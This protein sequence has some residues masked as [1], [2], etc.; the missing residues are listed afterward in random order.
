VVGMLDTI[1]R[2]RRI[3]PILE[4]EPEDDVAK[5][6]PGRL[7]GR[8]DVDRA[9]FRYHDD[10]PKVLDGVSLHAEPGEFVAIVGP[11]GSGK[12]TILRL[13]LGYETPVT[14]SVLYDG[15]NLTGLDITAVRRQLG[16]VLQAGRLN[17]GSIFDNIACGSVISI[18]EAWEA[19]HHAG[20]AE[21]RQNA[22]DVAQE[23]V[24]G[25]NDEHTGLAEVGPLVVQEVG[26]PVQRDDRLAGSRASLDHQRLVAGGP[27]DRIL[28][29]L[30]RRHHRQHL[31]LGRGGDRCEGALRAATRRGGP[32]ECGDQLRP[33]G[34]SARCTGHH[35]RRR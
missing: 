6:D 18:D 23:L 31:R 13:L 29:G 28:L 15:Q 27:D 17:T 33:T 20:L 2:G 1:T 24:G 3:K 7:M 25:S 8:V 26:G 22:P 4:A 21:R 14:G 9:V 35:G 32:R 12:S 10:G 34:R 11:S 19:A 16:V 5:T 30:D